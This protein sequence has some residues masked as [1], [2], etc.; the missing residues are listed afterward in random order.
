MDK[1]GE[2][3]HFGGEVIKN[4]AGYDVSRLQCGAFGTLGLLVELSIKTVPAPR[5]EITLC[6]QADEATALDSFV[7]WNRLL[8][9]IYSDPP[10]A[11]NFDPP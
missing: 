8:M 2:L 5:H 7:R 1:A 3:L 11:N 4:V 10:T 6:Q 9:A